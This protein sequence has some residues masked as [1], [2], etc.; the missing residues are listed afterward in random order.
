VIEGPDDENLRFSET[1]KRLGPR[2]LESLY[3]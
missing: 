1:A 2:T 3:G